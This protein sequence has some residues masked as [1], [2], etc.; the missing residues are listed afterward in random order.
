MKVVAIVQARMG[1]TRLPDKV[2]KKIGGVPMIELLLSRLSLAKELDQIIIA[3]S[4][5]SKNQP[6]AQHVEKLGY[7]C[8]RGSEDD[9][10]QR[11]LDAASAADADIVVRVTGDCPLIDPFLV[12]E[13]V[14]QF[15][16]SKVDYLSNTNPPHFQMV[17]Y[18]GF[19]RRCSQESCA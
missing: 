2:M 4:H 11:Y 5:D 8:V 13:C 3:T 12:D 17:R 6:L 18:G 9:V 14:V 19:H 15:I 1:S 16:D 7:L 10:L